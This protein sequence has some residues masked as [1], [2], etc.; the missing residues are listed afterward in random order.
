[1]SALYKIINKINNKFYLG[2]TKKISIRWAEHRRHLRYNKHTNSRLQAAWNKYGEE[3]FV[4]VVIK[5]LNDIDPLELLREEQILL[6]ELK[7]YDDSIGYN[8]SPN[9]HGGNRGSH[10]KK[11]IKQ[12]TL[13]GMFVKEWES[14]SAAERGLNVKRSIWDCVNGRQRS[15]RGFVWCYADQEPTFFDAYDSDCFK[16]QLDQY[17]KE[18]LFVKRWNSITEAISH[19]NNKE[20][21][22]AANG[23]LN[24][25]TASGFIWKFT[26]NTEPS[27]DFQSPL[28]IRPC[29]EH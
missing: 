2:S 25:R 9:A 17:T 18:G 12:Y 27:Y 13:D 11:A 22:Y 19:Y 16:K 10:F 26:N 15:S 29:D 28:A 21:S 6:D 24:R 4:F 20:I 5:E 1:M 14:I 23:Y 3:N 8:I 7:P